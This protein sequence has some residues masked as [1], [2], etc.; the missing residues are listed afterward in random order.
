MG[1]WKKLETSAVLLQ[2]SLSSQE[3]WDVSVEA[4][5]LLRSMTSTRH[6]YRKPSGIESSRRWSAQPQAFPGQRPVFR[7]RLLQNV[8]GCRKGL[9]FPLSCF[10]VQ[11]AQ[12]WAPN[13]SP[14]R[15]PAPGDS[16]KV[17][18]FMLTLPLRKFQGH[19]A[20]TQPT[21]THLHRTFSDC[22][23]SVASESRLDGCLSIKLSTL[24]LPYSCL[25]RAS[26][27]LSLFGCCSLLR[28]LQM[29]GV[30]NQFSN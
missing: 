24:I 5:G 10:S 4:S 7:G 12:G 14:A 2:T 20:E 11:K 16:E 13:S 19:R 8:A 9:C 25:L 17:S 21:D 3:C 1:V 27:Y 29:S 23:L 22:G 18:D 28:G 30:F 6:Q 15:E 26:W